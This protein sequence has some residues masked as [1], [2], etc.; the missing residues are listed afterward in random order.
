M[1]HANA[2]GVLTLTGTAGFGG[3]HVPRK[4]EMIEDE[5]RFNP[6]RPACFHA[7][8]AVAPMTIARGPSD[9]QRDYFFFAN[10]PDT[11]PIVIVSPSAIRGAPLSHCFSALPNPSVVNSPIDVPFNWIW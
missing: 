6:L 5:R 9:R 8:L 3:H 11:G 4:A 1:L 2:S 7:G 10:L